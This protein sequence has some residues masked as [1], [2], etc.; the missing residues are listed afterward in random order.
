MGGSQQQDA[1]QQQRM[2]AM[3]AGERVQLPAAAGRWLTVPARRR[4][5]ALLQP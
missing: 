2:A 4:A 1:Q 5:T 3:A